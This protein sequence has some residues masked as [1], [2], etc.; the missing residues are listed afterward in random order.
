[1]PEQGKDRRFS[2]LTCHLSPVP[3]PLS[4]VTRPLSPVPYSLL[5]VAGYPLGGRGEEWVYCPVTF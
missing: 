5:L 3:C 1:M 4:P 2:L